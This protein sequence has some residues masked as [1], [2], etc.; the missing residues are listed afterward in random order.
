MRRSGKRRRGE[1]GPP[2]ASAAS[3]TAW[4]GARATQSLSYT[5]ARCRAASALGWKSKRAST[6]CAA[7][8][9]EQ[10][11]L[12]FGESLSEQPRASR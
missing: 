1:T 12:P 7:A 11:R 4:T 2:N 5:A 10:G 9:A 6:D 8:L 3:N